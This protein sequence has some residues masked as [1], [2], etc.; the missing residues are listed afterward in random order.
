MN[1]GE[2]TEAAT[3]TTTT[4]TTSTDNISKK[5]I[6]TPDLENQT[7]NIKVSKSV[8]N[9]MYELAQ[10]SPLATISSICALFIVII[11]SIIIPRYIG[12]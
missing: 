7:P 4:T 8:F 12:F 10:K 2:N 5:E 6:K 11:L 3:T 9:S 1:E